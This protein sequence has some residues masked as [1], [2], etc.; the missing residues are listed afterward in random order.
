[1][2]IPIAKLIKAHKLRLNN[3]SHQDSKAVVYYQRAFIILC[4][5]VLIVT[6]AFFSLFINKFYS[7]THQNHF[8]AIFIGE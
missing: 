7:K 5:Y 4:R 3:R 6:N 1:M 8:D 2:L